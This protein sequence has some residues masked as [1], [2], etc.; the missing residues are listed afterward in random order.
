MFKLTTKEQFILAFLVIALLVGTVVKEWRARSE[1]A[2][3][4]EMFEP[5]TQDG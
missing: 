2:P 5:A 3:P 1:P 4:P